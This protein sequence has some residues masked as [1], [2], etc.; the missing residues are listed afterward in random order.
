MP[1]LAKGIP[2]PS[3]SPLAGLCDRVSWSPRAKP[4]FPAVPLC[5][6]STPILAAW[7]QR[8]GLNLACECEGIQSFQQQ[9]GSKSGLHSFERSLHS[10]G[11]WNH[12]PPL[13]LEGR[14]RAASRPGS[15]L[16]SRQAWPDS[17]RRGSQQME[18]TPRPLQATVWFWCPQRDAPNHARSPVSRW[19]LPKP[20]SITDRFPEIL[21]DGKSRPKLVV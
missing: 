7:Y 8:K 6:A 15:V 2:V 4:S 19:T 9:R 16:L 12:P 14:S 5:L 20:I 13:G 10:Q 21:Q 11:G 18:L 1:D 17:P 3:A